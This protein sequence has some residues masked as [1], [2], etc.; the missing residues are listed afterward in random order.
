MNVWDQLSAQVLG[1]IFSYFQ[2]PEH[3]GIEHITKVVKTITTEKSVLGHSITKI[4]KYVSTEDVFHSTATSI[5]AASKVALSGHS[6]QTGF[7]VVGSVASFDWSFFGLLLCIFCLLA[8]MGLCLGFSCYATIVCPARVHLPSLKFFRGFSGGDNGNSIEEHSDVDD[9]NTAGIPCT[10]LYRARRTL[11]FCVAEVKAHWV[12]HNPMFGFIGGVIVCRILDRIFCPVGYSDRRVP[13]NFPRNTLDVLAGLSYLLRQYGDVFREWLHPLTQT[14]SVALL[15]LKA[16][17]LIT[18]LIAGAAVTVVRKYASLDWKSRQQIWFNALSVVVEVCVCARAKITLV[19]DRTPGCCYS[20]FVASIPHLRNAWDWCSPRL[21]S[22]GCWCWSIDYWACEIRM[23]KLWIELILLP[24]QKVYDFYNNNRVT[25]L[26]KENHDLRAKHKMNCGELLVKLKTKDE[27]IRS[28]NHEI[29]ELTKN[30]EEANLRDL[31]HERRFNNRVTEIWEAARTETHI[32][33]SQLKIS[34]AR[35]RTAMSTNIDQRSTQEIYAKQTSQQIMMLEK[36]FERS[37]EESRKEHT[38]RV[39]EL[40]GENT[41]LRGQLKAKDEIIETKFL[42]SEPANQSFDIERLTQNDLQAIYDHFGWSTIK[43]EHKLFLEAGDWL[44]NA[45]NKLKADFA[46]YQS[47]C[48]AKNDG[49]VAD[50]EGRL[51]GTKTALTKAFE[52]NDNLTK[53]L[54]H[55]RENVRKSEQQSTALTRPQILIT[56]PELDLAAKA[57]FRTAFP[58][59]AKGE[60][61][62]GAQMGLNCLVKSLRLQYVFNDLTVED[63]QKICDDPETAAK[64][65]DARK[66]GPNAFEHDPHQL[67]LILELWSARH[68]PPML[69]G[70]KYHFYKIPG[71]SWMVLGPKE[72]ERVVWMARMIPTTDTQIPVCMALQKKPSAPVNAGSDGSAPANPM[73]SGG[74]DDGKAAEAATQKPQSDGKPS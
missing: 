62:R 19:I 25:Q 42:P 57:A 35:C 33:K 60:Q 31:T 18:L 73:P 58:H 63:L 10:W 21:A 55:L 66:E 65:K 38:H 52:K 67:A 12:I 64:I 17:W 72:G 4:A 11:N 46:E 56:H 23:A 37:K 30:L 14:T 8:L 47:A 54:E 43:A 27:M 15:S 29:T 59:G 6:S 40:E 36:E 28:K 3:S 2:K 49:L 32:W 26:Q 74:T 24:F 39:T 71:A 68:G 22:L 51:Q 1:T 13:T 20:A 53:Q 70:V 45:Y 50:Y 16:H 41:A 44:L 34:T 61:V 48:K 7:D 5:P 9:V 69:L